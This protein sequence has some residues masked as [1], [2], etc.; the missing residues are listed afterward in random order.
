MTATLLQG[1]RWIP[2]SSHATAD[3]FKARQKA[4]MRKA[5]AAE[6]AQKIERANVLPMK[7]KGK[8]NG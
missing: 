5:Q 6:K 8:R 1:M 3:D 7:E 2:S 4:R